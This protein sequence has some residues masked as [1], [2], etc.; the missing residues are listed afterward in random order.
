VP[1]QAALALMLLMDRPPLTDL[2]GPV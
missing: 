2:G 1:Q